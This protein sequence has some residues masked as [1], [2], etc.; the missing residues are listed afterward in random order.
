MLKKIMISA[1][2]G[3]SSFAYANVNAIVSIVPQQTF[4]KAIG[5]D[6]VNISLMVPTGSSPHTYEPK[7]SQMRDISK[8]DIY[9]SIGVEFEEAWLPKFVTQNK[10]MK[11]VDIGAGVVKIAIDKH[12]DHGHES[13]EKKK[14]KVDTHE[15]AFDPHIWTSV[16][17]IKIIAKNI[18]ENLVALDKENA[19]YYKVNYDKLLV[20][21]NKTDETIK[22]ILKDTPPKSKFMV[23]HPSWGYFADQYN[24]TQFAI[25]AGGKNPTPKHMVY[26]IDEAKEEKVKAIFTAPEFSE[27]IAISIAKEVGVPVVKVSPLH[28]KVCENLINLAKAIANK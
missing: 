26:L 7:P 5:G 17:N 6:K 21:L 3:M 15:D 28:P 8:A 20:K 18:F 19:D 13:A 14:P 22:E 12:E 24:L 10:K 27:S 9:L 2:I 1:M 11:V 16:A 23:F 25:E 4:V